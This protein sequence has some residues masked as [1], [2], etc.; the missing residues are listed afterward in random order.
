MIIALALA[1]RT[2]SLS[3]NDLERA[4]SS[5]G[6]P[7]RP[8]PVTPSEPAGWREKDLRP[9]ATVCARA[10]CTILGRGVIVLSGGGGR[11]GRPSEYDTSSICKPAELLSY[12]QICIFNR[13]SQ[14]Q[15]ELATTIN[16]IDLCHKW[17]ESYF[18][19][20]ARP[21]QNNSHS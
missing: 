2:A 7:P 13:A 4:S 19:T 12:C 8:P 14:A 1:G 9:Y 6:H 11:G 5:R 21:C 16:S 3:G 18:N 20:G 15:T 17:V 10:S